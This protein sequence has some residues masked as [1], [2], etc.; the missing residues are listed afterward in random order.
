MQV[1]LAVPWHFKGPA[2]D[3]GLALVKASV[4][5]QLG[6]SHSYPGPTE[7]AIKCVCFVATN[8]FSRANHRQLL[9]LVC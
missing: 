2:W 9:V 3:L 1:D 8:R 4:G 5:A 7:V 6:P